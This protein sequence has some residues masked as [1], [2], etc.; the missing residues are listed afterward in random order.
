[1]L[2]IGGILS[3]W[4]RR[5][6]IVRHLNILRTSGFGRVLK[7]EFLSTGERSAYI[8]WGAPIIFLGSIYSLWVSY[9]VVQRFHKPF[10]TLV[11]YTGKRGTV[12][13]VGHRIFSMSG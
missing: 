11:H 8:I 3:C 9:E 1:M 13:V 10:C 2:E 7:T 5:N 12:T 4:P 6:Y